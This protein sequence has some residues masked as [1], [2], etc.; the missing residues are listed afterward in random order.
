MLDALWASADGVAVYG[1]F[2]SV[3][4]AVGAAGLACIGLSARQWL[5]DNVKRKNV[6]RCRTRHPRPALTVPVTPEE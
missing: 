2:V 5:T 3:D 4:D 6:P 1:E